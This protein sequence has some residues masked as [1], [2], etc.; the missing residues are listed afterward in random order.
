MTGIENGIMAGT[1]NETELAPEEETETGTGIET[2]IGIEIETE[3]GKGK[4][5]KETVTVGEIDLAKIVLIMV[6]TVLRRVTCHQGMVIL[7]YRQWMEI[8][9]VRVLVLWAL[10]LAPGVLCGAIQVVQWVLWDQWEDQWAPWDQWEGLWALWGQ[11]AQWVQWDLLE[12][13][14]Q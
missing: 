7:L 3:T 13:D 4:S 5:V 12:K 2:E 10:D 6:E 1:E 8:S 11:W 14:R 9:L